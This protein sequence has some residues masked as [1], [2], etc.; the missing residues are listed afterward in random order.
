MF[1]LYKGERKIYKLLHIY[2]EGGKGRE[3][4]GV[5]YLEGGKE[6]GTRSY[7]SLDIGREA[8]NKER[9]TWKGEGEEAPS[10]CRE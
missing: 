4:Q 7:I 5:N 1:L 9:F 8:G 2:L 6:G 3:K 10:L